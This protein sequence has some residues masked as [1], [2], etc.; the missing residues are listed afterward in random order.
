M[1]IVEM[2][3]GL[4]IM[5]RYSPSGIHTRIPGASNDLIYG[6]ADNTTPFTTEELEELDRL[7]W[8]YSLEHE[9]WVHFC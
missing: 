5:I 7:G 1:T 3:A 4:M 8:F 9:R 2:V 6:P